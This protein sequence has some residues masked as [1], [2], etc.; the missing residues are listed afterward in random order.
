MARQ[1]D[2]GARFVELPSVDHLPYV[3]NTEALIGELEEFFTGTHHHPELHRVLTTVPFADIVD[4]TAHIADIGDLHWRDLKA[5]YLT[6]ARREIDRYRGRFVDSAGDS[7]FATFDGPARA[8]RAA[9][10]IS[11]G[12]G[13]LGIA[14]RVGLHTG[15][16]E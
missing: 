16:V 13:G 4:S 15:E 6:L 8:I 3:G 9:R 2:S 1:S 10:A 14:V 12:V 5:Q 7:V 11:D